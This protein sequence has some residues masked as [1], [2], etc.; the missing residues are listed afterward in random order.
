MAMCII[1]LKKCKVSQNELINEAKKR[2]IKKRAN[3]QMNGMIDT[4]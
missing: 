3:N 4:V 2:G 1:W